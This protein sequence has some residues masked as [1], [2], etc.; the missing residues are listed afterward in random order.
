M[1]N[2]TNIIMIVL[3]CHIPDIQQYRIQKALDFVSIPQV[4]SS[5]WFLTGGI[6]NA[7]ETHVETAQQSEASIMKSSFSSDFNVILD[8]GARNTAENFANFKAWFTETFAGTT[9]LPQVV[10]TT[11][12]FHKQRAEKIF[13]GI[14]HDLPIDPTWNLSEYACPTCWSDEFIHMR[15]VEND[16]KKA[17]NR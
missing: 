11:S 1:V 5:V 14:F 6:K 4:D 15:N 12:A 9:T 10:I 2:L 16:V 7:I 13:Q 3:G 17:L 8:D